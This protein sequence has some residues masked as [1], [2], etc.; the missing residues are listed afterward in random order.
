MLSDHDNKRKIVHPQSGIE[1]S[2]GVDEEDNVL[3]CILDD[4]RI[5]IF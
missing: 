4:I 3:H 5:G 2:F 1:Q